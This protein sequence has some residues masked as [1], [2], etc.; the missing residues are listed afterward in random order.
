MVDYRDFAIE[1]TEDM[2]YSAEQMLVAALKYMSQDDVKDML[3]ANEYPMS[4]EEDED[5]Q[6]RDEEMQEE[7]DQQIEEDLLA[8]YPN[9]IAE[10]EVLKKDF[11]GMAN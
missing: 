3:E 10:L 11:L 1:L 2:G 4:C 9:A 7:I 6:A 8:R 5:L